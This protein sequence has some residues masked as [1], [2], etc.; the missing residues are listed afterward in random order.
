MGAGGEFYEHYAGATAPVLSSS[1]LTFYSLAIRILLGGT[2]PALLFF[3]P[4]AMIAIHLYTDRVIAEMRELAA[5]P[6]QELGERLIEQGYRGWSDRETD[7]SW[8]AKWH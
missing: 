5:L 7:M 1:L 6:P 8:R 3:A 4:K 2:A